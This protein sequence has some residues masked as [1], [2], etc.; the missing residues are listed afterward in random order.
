MWSTDITYFPKYKKNNIFGTDKLVQF[1]QVFGVHMCKLHRHL[2]DGTVKF[3][4]FRQVFGL[5]RVQYMGL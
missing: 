1:R 4:W 2:V 3:V 5:L